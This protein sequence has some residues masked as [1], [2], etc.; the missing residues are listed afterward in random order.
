MRRHAT[1]NTIK[2]SDLIE[3]YIACQDLENSW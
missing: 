2:L 3:P 1:R